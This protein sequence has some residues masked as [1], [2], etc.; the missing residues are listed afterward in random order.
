MRFEST[1]AQSPTVFSHYET[2][3]Q[4]LD[5][6]SLSVFGEHPTSC[7]PH[8]RCHERPGAQVLLCEQ[9]LVRFLLSAHPPPICVLS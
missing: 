3:S 9:L 4:L 7:G 6:E 5:Y 8:N 1:R 2:H